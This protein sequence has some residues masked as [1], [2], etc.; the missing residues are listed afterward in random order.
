MNVERITEPS[1]HCAM[2]HGLTPC[3]HTV[4]WLVMLPVA[5]S[6]YMCQHHLDH[7]YTLIGQALEKS[8]VPALQRYMVSITP[9]KD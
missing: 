1:H 8:S 7:L 2:Y 3:E 5:R 6:I 9:Y 4:Q